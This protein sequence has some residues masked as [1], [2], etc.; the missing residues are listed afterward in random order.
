MKTFC[1]LLTT[2]LLLGLSAAAQ[3]TN[4]S[5]LL[6]ITIVESGR[7]RMIVTGEDSTIEV[8][9][10]TLKDNYSLGF[11]LKNVEANNL[12]LIQML[13]SYYDKG[14]K[15]I[16]IDPIGINPGED[17]MTRYILSKEY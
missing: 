1:I 13:K 3:Q 17:Y 2:V 12:W 15:L 11:N 7:T 16:G 8:K 4:K 5:Q 9:K 10:I 6:M 14:W